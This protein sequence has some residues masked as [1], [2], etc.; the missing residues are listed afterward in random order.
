[1]RD[2]RKS[3]SDE[4]KNKPE[5]HILDIVND[6]DDI[7]IKVS[8]SPEYGMY[9]TVG[10]KEQQVFGRDA[11][12]CKFYFFDSSACSNAISRG[13]N[14]SS[15]S[16]LNMKSG[17]CDNMDLDEVFTGVTKAHPCHNSHIAFTFTEKLKQCLN[18][19]PE[20]GKKVFADENG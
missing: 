4:L 9:L 3:V 11:L 16:G 2:A 20:N 17:K 1:M 14:Q 6:I 15:S 5:R 19:I 10:E 8:K 12:N 13:K 18:S 7:G